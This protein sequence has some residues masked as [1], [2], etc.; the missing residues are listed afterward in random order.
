ML[1]NFKRHGL[2]SNGDNKYKN[3][4]NTQMSRWLL[5]THRINQLADLR[6]SYTAVY[7][8]CNHTTQHTLARYISDMIELHPH[9]VTLNMHI[10]RKFPVWN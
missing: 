6:H 2:T 8:L 1:T 5:E 4:A 10:Y 3:I 7:V 9:L